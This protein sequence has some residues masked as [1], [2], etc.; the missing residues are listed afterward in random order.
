[1][2]LNVGATRHKTEEEEEEERLMQIHS[3]PL[4]AAFGA[5]KIAVRCFSI[6]RT[7]RMDLRG[8]FFSRWLLERTRFDEL[9]S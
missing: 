4:G 7:Q 2:H 1:M 5:V 3:L 8:G 6:P 9:Q